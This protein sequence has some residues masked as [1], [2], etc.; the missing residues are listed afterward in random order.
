MDKS[1]SR[2][3]ARRIWIEVNGPIPKG[4]QLHHR[5]G[6]PYNNSLDNLMVCTPEEHIKLHEEMGHKIQPNFIAR[7]DFF[8]QMSPEEQAAFREKGRI[9]GLKVKPRKWTDEDKLIA[10]QRNAERSNCVEMVE[11][12]TGKIVKEFFSIKEASEELGMQRA[13]IRRV[14]KGQRKSWRGYVFRY[15]EK[16]R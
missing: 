9:N 5:D 15:K 11:L 1:L 3:H 4:M 10:Q 14:I 12:K 2:Y 13:H 8:S 16:R 6:N 7:A